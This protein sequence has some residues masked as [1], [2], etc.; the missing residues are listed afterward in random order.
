MTFKDIIR[1][2]LRANQESPSVRVWDME[3]IEDAMRVARES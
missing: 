2:S 1:L 3:D